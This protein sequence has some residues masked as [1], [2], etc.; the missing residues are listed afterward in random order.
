MT[1]DFDT[2]LRRALQQRAQQVSGPEDPLPDIHRRAHRQTWTR[3]TGATLAVVAVLAAGG[4]ATNPLADRFLQTE[5]AVEPPAAPEVTDETAP[6]PPLTDTATCEGAEHGL[7]YRVAYPEAWWASADDGDACRW[8]HPE[9]YDLPEEARDVADIAIMLRVHDEPA[10]D[11]RDLDPDRH[12]LVSESEA[13]VAGRPAV[14]QEYTLELDGLMPE[15]TRVYRYLVDVGELTL[16]GQATD[17]APAADFEEHRTVLDA[18]MTSLEIVDEPGAY[19]AIDLIGEPGREDVA[20]EPFPGEGAPAHLADVRVSRQD[21]FDR[22]VFEFAAGAAPGY[23][24]GYTDA[25]IQTAPDGEGLDVAGR[26]FLEVQAAPA[27]AVDRSGDEPVGTYDGPA[28]IGAEETAAV[29]EVARVGDHDGELTWVLG[30][31]DR[32]PFAVRLLEEPHRLVV[33]VATEVEVDPAPGVAL[34]AEPECVQPG[35]RFTAVASGLEPGA[36]YSVL[37]DPRP[38]TGLERGAHGTAGDDGVLEV[39]A[40]LPDDAEPGGYTLTVHP[41][42]GVEAGQ[43]QASADLEIAQACPSA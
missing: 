13:T 26:A 1:E 39:P 31:D 28:R 37:I 7:G 16:Y 14:V 18:M 19:D 11:L 33:D 12:D 3:R 34:A 43:A 9:P 2:Q 10:A 5:V 29:A 35:D 27:T 17:V 22:V 36:E 32:R 20:S 38:S 6:E 30:V 23:A 15:G 21:G 25:P 41:F 24:A 8:F 40:R 42:D 4:V